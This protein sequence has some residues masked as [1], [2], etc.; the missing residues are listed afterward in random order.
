[1]HRVGRNGRSAKELS[2]VLGSRI[3]NPE[4][5]GSVIGLLT[6]VSR[7][8]GIR[9]PFWPGR[10]QQVSWRKRDVNHFS[11]NPCLIFH[12]V[13]VIL[14][15]PLW[16]LWRTDPNHPPLLLSGYL[17]PLFI[18]SRS[19]RSPSSFHALSVFHLFSSCL[20]N[21]VVLVKG[22]SRL[23]LSIHSHS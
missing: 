18:K 5:S 2:A 10:S 21:I 22:L 23:I 11:E 15:C 4:L 20:S 6:S 7:G 14:A 1:M 13:F 9:S 17:H 3:I 19:L 16:E 12:I 8:G